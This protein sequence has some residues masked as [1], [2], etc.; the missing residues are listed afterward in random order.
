M[1][2]FIAIRQRNSAAGAHLR[3]DFSGNRRNE[4]FTIL[5]NRG[6]TIALVTLNL[7]GGTFWE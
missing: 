7:L 4:V 2:A 3:R 1:T 5:E 6:L